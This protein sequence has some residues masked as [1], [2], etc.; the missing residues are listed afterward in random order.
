MNMKIDDLIKHERK[1]ETFNKYYENEGEKLTNA[2]ALYKAREQAGLTQQELAKRSH[3]TQ[4]TISRIERGVNISFK[5][6]QLIAHA[7]GKKLTVQ[8]N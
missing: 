8:F 4:A 3:V 5:K 2:I 1:D 7:L 6:L